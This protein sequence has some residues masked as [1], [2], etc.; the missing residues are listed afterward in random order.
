MSGVEVLGVVA[1]AVQLVDC[2]LRISNTLLEISERLHEYPARLHSHVDQVKHLIQAARLAEGNPSLHTPTIHAHVK[3]TLAAAAEL[4]T[5]LERIAVDYSQKSWA[6]RYLKII[7][8]GAFEE[9]QLV[10]K[11]VNLERQKSDLI[12]C[13]SVVHSDALA[14]I[15]E[16]VDWLVDI[17]SC[18]MESRV[19]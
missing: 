10:A 18:H 11:F 15:Q 13:I 5:T 6:H 19:C 4:Q 17:I 3:T 1:S 14:E 16:G 8:R 7:L 12:F 9:R 2:V